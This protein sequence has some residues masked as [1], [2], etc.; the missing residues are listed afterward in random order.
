M[1]VEY[2]RQALSDLRDI[3]A[4]YADSDNPGTAAKVAARIQEVV[5]RIASAPNSGRLVIERSHVRMCRC[6]IIDIISSIF[7]K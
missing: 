7:I 1:K 4:Y 6:C 3:A 2:G 5:A